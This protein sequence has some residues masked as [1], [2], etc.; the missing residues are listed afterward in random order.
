MPHQFMQQKLI[1]SRR[2]SIA[3]LLIVSVG[4][5][6]SQGFIETSFY[7]K[8]NPILKYSI[9]FIWLLLVDLIGLWGWKSSAQKWMYSTWFY[10]Y[11]VV[12]ITLIVLG[13][14]DIYLLPIATYIKKDISHFRAFFLSPAFFVVLFFLSKIQR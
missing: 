2:L 10:T 14:I 5:L 7:V 8:A 12:I 1:P 6:I 11:S 13:L 4:I 9:Y 3:L